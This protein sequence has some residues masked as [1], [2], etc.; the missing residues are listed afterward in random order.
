MCESSSC[1]NCCVTEC[2]QEKANLLGY[3]KNIYQLI[4]KAAT[5]SILRVLFVGCLNSYIV[6]NNNLSHDIVVIRLYLHML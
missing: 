2:F 4:Q 5:F 6:I 3:Y 1:S